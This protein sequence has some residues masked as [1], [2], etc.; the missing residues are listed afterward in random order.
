MMM[1]IERSRDFTGSLKVFSYIT[2]DLWLKQDSS[3]STI[4]YVR[5]NW[6]SWS[7]P[8][9]TQVI[10]VYESLPTY[11]PQPLVHIKGHAPRD[12]T[13]LCCMLLDIVVTT[14]KS[15]ANAALGRYVSSQKRCHLIVK[16]TFC[17]SQQDTSILTNNFHSGYY[18]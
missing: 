12:F 9:Q 6:A 14:S 3:I 18:S 5:M 17:T 4:L 15:V 10:M 1:L 11:L 13:L 7:S 8:T 2:F 16:P